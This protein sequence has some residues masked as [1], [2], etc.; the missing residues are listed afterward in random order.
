MKGNC[1][2][3]K[4]SP[5]S[6]QGPQGEHEPAQRECERAHTASEEHE[7]TSPEPDSENA[8]NPPAAATA[9]NDLDGVEGDHEQP[10]PDTQQT[11]SIPGTPTRRYPTRSRRPPTD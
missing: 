6:F 10:H 5:V 2:T 1:D 7:P 8:T 9:P 3:I 11:E 4:K